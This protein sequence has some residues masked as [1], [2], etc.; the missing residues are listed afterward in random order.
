MAAAKKDRQRR[1][2]KLIGL[3]ILLTTIFLAELFLATWCRVQSVRIGMEI[4]QAT[5]HQKQLAAFKNN[6][7]IERARLRSP[8]HLARV[9]R[10]DLGLDMPTSEQVIVIP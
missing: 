9:A 1:T 5:A 8:A 3:W 10:N 2:G 4:S 7:T 6:L